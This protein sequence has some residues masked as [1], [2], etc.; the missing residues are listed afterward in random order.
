MALGMVSWITACIVSV[1]NFTNP[2]LGLG[3]REVSVVSLKD[4]ITGNIDRP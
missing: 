2:S 1:I 4:Y 3:Q